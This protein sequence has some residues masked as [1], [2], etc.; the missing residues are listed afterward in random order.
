MDNHAAVHIYDKVQQNSP[1]AEIKAQEISHKKVNED[2]DAELERLIASQKTRIKVI[3]CG[4]AGNNTINRIS[5]IG[6]KGIETIAINTDA[7]DLLYTSAERKLLIGRE[8]THGLGA[9]SNPRIGEEAAKESEHEL[10]RLLEGCDMIFITCGMGG[11]TGTGSAPFVA[12][13]AKKMGV[14]QQLISKI[15]SG[16][17]N[18]SLETL[19][20][21]V[22][23]LGMTLKIGVGKRKK[24]E[25]ALEF[26]A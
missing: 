2:I 13:L 3:G 21:F 5:E 15:E 17:D 11:G 14:S 1:V 25:G 18:I 12:Q 6:V 10:K 16:D 4:G 23:I 24:E 7:Q 19:V 9:G 20:K 22:Y 26:A 8:L